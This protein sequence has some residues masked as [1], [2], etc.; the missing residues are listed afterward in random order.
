MIVKRETLVCIKTR[1]LNIAKDAHLTEYN[2]HV[3]TYACTSSS[4]TFDEP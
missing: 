2:M 3:S 4:L 1:Q